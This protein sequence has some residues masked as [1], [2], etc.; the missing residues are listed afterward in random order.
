VRVYTAHYRPTLPPADREI[1]LVK[2]GLCWP[3]LVLS[4]LWA[5]WHRMWIEAIVFVAAPIALELATEFFGLTPLGVS[6]AGLGFSLLVGYVANDLR[7]ASLERRGF[8]TAGLVAGRDHD[9]ALARLV[10]ARPELARQP[11]PFAAFP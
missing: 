10:D 5:I 6:A 1:V 2:E 3:A 11:T 8:R 9:T 4:P 7:R